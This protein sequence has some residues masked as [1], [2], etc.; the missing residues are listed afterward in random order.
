VILVF[1]I[2]FLTYC[3]FPTETSKKK[4]EYETAMKLD[5]Y[6]K[7]Q[8]YLKYVGTPAFTWK[9]DSL[10]LK[11]LDYKVKSII[12]DNIEYPTLSDTTTLKIL[13]ATYG[14][15]SAAQ[16]LYT[17]EWK[18]RREMFADMLGM[19]TEVR[20]IALEKKNDFR[21]LYK[22]APDSLKEFI[23]TG[24]VKKLAAAEYIYNNVSD[25]SVIN[26]LKKL[27]FTDR[28]VLD[29]HWCAR[30]VPDQQIL[31]LLSHLSFSEA[32]DFTR[33]FEHNQKF[34]K[35]LLRTRFKEASI[36]EMVT[37]ADRSVS[38][39]TVLTVLQKKPLRELLEY[40]LEELDFTTDFYRDYCKMIITKV[41]TDDD[42]VAV[43]DYFSNNIGY[44]ELL[45][46]N[47]GGCQKS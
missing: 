16:F 39:I 35:N 28:E 4:D 40:N 29:N 9:S 1:V 44:L 33:R 20:E 38:K 27:T 2:A 42:Y 32:L 12:A 21:W 34:R 30:Y 41:K 8:Y 43:A 23:L 17:V 7:A 25:T 6:A 15:K 19:S 11:D 3:Y 22:L 13:I 24:Q 10:L 46:K 14:R 5:D 45:R 26:T 37:L 18:G 31:T 47:K 36:E